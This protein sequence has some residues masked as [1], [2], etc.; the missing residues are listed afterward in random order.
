MPGDE[1]PILICFDDSEPSR[2][3]IAEAARLF[4]GARTVVLHV[5]RS[6]ES[7]VAFRYSAAGVSGALKDALDEVDSAG[8]EVA[9]AIAEEGAKLARD[10]G[11][12]AE[13]LAV[14]AEE[15]MDEV[16]AK[17]AER[18]DASLIVM[19]SRRLRPIQAL[20]LGGFSGA[21]LHRSKRPV[22]VVPAL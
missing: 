17:E 10:A 4:P 14:E 3:A 18:L 15:H 6:I 12:E 22:L 8:Q 5:W 16:V 19:G 7:T 1:R 9:Q 2:H 21:A 13:P 11:F 20:A